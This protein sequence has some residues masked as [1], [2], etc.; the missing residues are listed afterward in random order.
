MITFTRA[1]LCHTLHKSA[2]RYGS[3]TGTR[4]D[5]GHSSQCLCLYQHVS[6]PSQKRLSEAFIQRSVMPHQIQVHLNKLEC[7]GKVHLFQ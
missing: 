7:R 1:P 6:E 4:A 2:V 3:D 5:C